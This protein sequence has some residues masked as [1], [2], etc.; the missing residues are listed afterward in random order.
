MFDDLLLL[1]KGGEVVYHG[2]TGKGSHDLVHY[3]ESLGAPRIELGENPANWMLRLIGDDDMGELP[4]NFRL[5]TQFHD[6]RE[7][8]A[9]I[10]TQPEPDVSQKIE[11]AEQFA[12]IKSYRQPLVT[13]RVR[14]IYWRSPAYN[15]A[16]LMVSGTVAFVL[17]S[18]FLWARFDNDFTEADIRA[19]LS[20]VFLSFIITGM[21]AIFGSIPVMTKLRDMFYRHRI[22]G[23]YGSSS[24][25][26][27]LGAAEKPFILFSSTIFTAVF[28]STASMMD[29]EGKRFFRG[30]LGFWGF[31]TFNFAI[32]SYFGQAF[33]CL[34][35]PT[36]TAIILSGIFIGLNNFF[37]GLIVRP[38]FM[39][40]S[41]FALPYYIC[42]GHYVFEGLVT[43]LYAED[44][45]Y[46]FA[47]N[48]SDFWLMLVAKECAADAVS[49][50]ACCTGTSLDEVCIGTVDE[51]I[52][53]FFGN[54]F[55][56]RHTPRNAMILGFV[57]IL[58]RLL[59]FLS[60]KYIRFSK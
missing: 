16:R 5:S 36:A 25:G 54:H 32:Y 40:G 51:Y 37:S 11:Y 27:A 31:F 21:L 22:A 3:F 59:T 12:T 26:M 44:Q 43:S 23:M 4:K 58:T 60:L 53:V 30:L 33:V 42:P 29:S 57:L 1:R 56:I 45:R 6:M 50:E 15:L 48:G 28:L 35:K 18:L 41:F 20:V 7:E 19:R 52:R 8:L 47:D 55:V 39:V 46:V 14:A 38:Q 9:L 34:V 10:A 2:P 17:G 24:I 49:Q 13:S